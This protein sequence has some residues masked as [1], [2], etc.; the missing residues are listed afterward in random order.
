MR[1]ARYCTV[2]M[3]AF[4]LGACGHGKA[5]EDQADAAAP[6][7]QSSTP[8]QSAAQAPA[9]APAPDTAAPDTDATRPLQVSDLD[10]YV[11][12]MQKEIELRQAASDKA[13]KAKAGNDQATEISGLAELTSV[14]VTNAGARAAGVDR[15]RY[16][17]ITHA[18]DRVLGTLEMNAMM[19]KM[20]DAAQ[21]QKFQ[22]DPYAGLA[23]EVVAALKSRHDEL[24][25]LRT[26]NMTI[27][28]NARNL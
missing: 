12:G 28:A 4:S 20:G 11:K 1:Y 17:F 6:N 13:A 16:D 14:E 15:A 21:T 19:A 25:K 10:A 26:Q 27:L 8:P 22:S 9:V 18:I 24:A 3:L 2:L 23:P 7:A 5:P